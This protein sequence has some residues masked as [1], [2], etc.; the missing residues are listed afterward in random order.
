MYRVSRVLLFISV[1][2]GGCTSEQ[3]D[4][5]VS[6][7]ATP[8]GAKDLQLETLDEITDDPYATLIESEDGSLK[9][10]TAPD[11]VEEKTSS[12]LPD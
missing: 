9:V 1:V 3:A 6:A 12:R 5:D 8:P 7:T 11:V 2:L 10:L 4:R